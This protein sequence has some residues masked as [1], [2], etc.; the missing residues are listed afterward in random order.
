MLFLATVEE[1][2][3]LVGLLIFSNGVATVSVV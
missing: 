3:L 1:V 2:A